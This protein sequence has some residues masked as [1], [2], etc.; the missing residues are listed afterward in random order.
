DAGE[1]SQASVAGGS[2]D[3]GG[4]GPNEEEYVNQYKQQRQPQ[5]TFQKVSTM[6]D[7]MNRKGFDKNKAHI[8]IKL[9]IYLNFKEKNYRLRCLQ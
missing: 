9:F 8:F 5:L 2:V 3:G 1:V 4:D 7:N 6:V